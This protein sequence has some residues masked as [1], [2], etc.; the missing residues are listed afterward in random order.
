MTTQPEFLV[1]L[2][3]GGDAD[4]RQVRRAYARELKQIDQERDLEGFQ[5][6]RACYEAALDW[7]AHRAGHAEPA[8]APVQV[9]EPVM[10]A[11]A[12]PAASPPA[13]TGQQVNP[14]LLVDGV[15]ADLRVRMAALAAQPERMGREETT[16]VAPWTAA[17][18]EALA[19]PRL[20]NLTARVIFE[21]RIAALLAEGWQPGHH[22]LLPAAIEAFGWNDDRHALER[23]GSAGAHLDEALEQRVVFQSQDILVRT[24]QREVLHLLRQGEPPDAHTLNGYAR[25]L[26]T[27]TDH[28][29]TLL[30]V[31]A[32]HRIAVAW[33]TRITDD[34]LAAGSAAQGHERS[35]WDRDTTPHWAIGFMVV[36]LIRIVFTFLTHDTP[37]PPANQAA[38]GFPRLDDAERRERL[39]HP[40]PIYEDEP[41]TE[42]RVEAI[43]KAIRYSPGKDVPLGEQVAEIQVVLDANGSILGLN[44]LKSQGDPAYA[45][46]V[47][48]AIRA[49]GP[50]PPK[51]SKAFT[52][53]YRATL[54]RPLPP[55]RA[56]GILKRVDYR[57]RKGAPAGAQ[58]VKFGVIL[59]EH[60]AIRTVDSLIAPSDPAYAEAV[61]QAIRL[62]APFPP[63]IPR[64]FFVDFSTK[65]PRKPSSASA[66]PADKD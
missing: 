31:V 22:L 23:L 21:H 13:E 53:V 55:E 34:M 4:G 33:R 14:L 49:T 50:F 54:M 9:E 6:L 57:P 38:H 10:K 3:L 61:E 29:P 63:E 48:Q 66:P 2:G 56:T 64:F 25:A 15:F 28:F 37:Q 7:A 12:A 20:L 62:G 41:V 1:R 17:L 46:A 24:Q 26:V 60:G 32:P 43:R 45:D 65:T 19:D 52:L 16:L 47:A 51:T 58:R 8:P 42:E 18:R 36:V 30:G 11:E 35:H 27:L 59:D 5:Y 39:R 40:K 44:R